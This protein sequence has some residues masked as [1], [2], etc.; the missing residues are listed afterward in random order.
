MYTKCKHTGI[1]DSLGKPLFGSEMWSL[2]EFMFHI[3]ITQVKGEIS[4]G[5]LFYRNKTSTV[6]QL[7]SLKASVSN[8][9]NKLQRVSFLPLISIFTN[10]SSRGSLLYLVPSVCLF[11]RDGPVIGVPVCTGGGQ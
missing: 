9:V 3:Y 8:P 2:L 1:R 5:L 7:K 11:C 4:I 6:K 10:I